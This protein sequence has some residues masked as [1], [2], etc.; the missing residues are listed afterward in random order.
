MGQ[1]TLPRQD[2]SRFLD[3]LELLN[4]LAVKRFAR[5]PF[6]ADGACWS[7]F[8]VDQGQSRALVCVGEHQELP[9][10]VVITVS[11]DLRR[12]LCFWRLL[13]DYFLGQQLSQILEQ[14]GGRA[15]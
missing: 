7:R 5:D 6:V 10:D 3:Q 14:I 2:Q 1:Y 13:G 12:V 8:T 9:N 11:I 4:E 15:L